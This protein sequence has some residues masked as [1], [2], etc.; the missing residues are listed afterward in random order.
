[1]F[2]IDQLKKSD[3]R[4]QAVALG[5]LLGVSLLLAGLWYVQVIASKRF[6]T[7]LNNQS[8]RMVRLPGLRGQIQDRNRLPL[9]ENRAAFNVNLYLEELRG[10]F[11]AEFLGQ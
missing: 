10:P 11:Q 4:L 2:I 8:F 3:R 5:I 7:H 6:I 1:M 9:A